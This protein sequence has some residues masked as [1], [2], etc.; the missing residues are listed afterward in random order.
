MDFPVAISFLLPLAG[1]FVVALTLGY[2][3]SN[4]IGV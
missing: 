3:E 1:I 2:Y 4:N